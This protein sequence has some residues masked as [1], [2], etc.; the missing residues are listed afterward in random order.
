MPEL[1]GEHKPPVCRDCG[2]AINIWYGQGLEGDGVPFVTPHV[3]PCRRCSETERLRGWV[4]CLGHIIE[5]RE[6]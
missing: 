4:E 2:G 3:T 5:D 6:R 1:T